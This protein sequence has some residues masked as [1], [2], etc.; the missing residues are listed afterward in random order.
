MWLV[1]S[2]FS[3]NTKYEGVLHRSGSRTFKLSYLFSRA[4]SYH[5]LFVY[6]LCDQFFLYNTIAIASVALFP[7]PVQSFPFS[8]PVSFSLFSPT[9]HLTYVGIIVVSCVLC[10]VLGTYC[11]RI[12][13]FALRHVAAIQSKD[14]EG[15]KIKSGQVWSLTIS[16][17][18]NTTRSYHDITSL[19]TNGCTNRP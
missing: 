17:L 12:L 8:F 6:Y 4:H 18:G 1:I 2:Y 14:E 19:I 13:S 7:F 15:N 3:L 11:L 5:L 9:R 16:S 10:M